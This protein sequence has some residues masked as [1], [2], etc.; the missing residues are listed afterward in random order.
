MSFNPNA[1]RELIHFLLLPH[2]QQV[3]AI[4][5]LHRLGWSDYGIAAATRLSVEQIRRLIGEAAHA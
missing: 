3:E 4:Y 5:R 1:P 2:E